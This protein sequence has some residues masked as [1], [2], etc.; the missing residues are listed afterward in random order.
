VN[1]GM[2][3]MFRG[4]KGAK[5]DDGP[6]GDKGAQ[7]PKGD[8]GEPLSAALR[9][10]IAYLLVLAIALSAANLAWTKHEVDANNA[11]QAAQQAAARRQGEHVVR[12]LCTSFGNI[13]DLK[14]PPGSAAANPSRAYEQQLHVRLDQ[15]GADLGCR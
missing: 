10:A 5:G 1:E 13:A 6:R 2:E 3:A 11:A 8:K 15:L 14:P 12:L 9:R 7:G 4:A